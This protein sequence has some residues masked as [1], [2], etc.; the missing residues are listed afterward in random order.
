MESAMAYHRTRFVTNDITVQ[1]MIRDMK[2]YNYFFICYRSENYYEGRREIQKIL[3]EFQIK[4]DVLFCQEQPSGEFI[5]SL[6]CRLKFNGGVQTVD[7]LW[8]LLRIRNDRQL[9]C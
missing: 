4:M 2:S 8:E 1:E 6:Y 5:L 3:S 9:G 7:R